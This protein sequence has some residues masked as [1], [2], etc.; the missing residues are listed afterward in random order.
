MF[1]TLGA[2]R[3]NLEK[4]SEAIFFFTAETVMSCSPEQQ[5]VSV[6][7]ITETNG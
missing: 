5:F 6:Y 1:H 7:I 2:L 3:N 4:L